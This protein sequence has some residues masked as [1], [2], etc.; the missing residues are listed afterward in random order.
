MPWPPYNTPGE[1]WPLT[2]PQVQKK[3]DMERDFAGYGNN[4][5][6]VVWP[7]NARIAVSLVVND[8]E[9]SEQS[10]PDVVNDAVD[11]TGV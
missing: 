7:N 9:G 3:R 11:T 2:S 1:I 5:P 4:P 6:Q 10:F 8:E